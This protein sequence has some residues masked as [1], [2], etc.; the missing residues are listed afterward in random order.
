MPFLL[1]QTALAWHAPTLLLPRLRLDRKPKFELT[2]SSLVANSK[3]RGNS[4]DS[5]EGSPGCEELPQRDG[6]SGV[7]DEG[8][9]KGADHPPHLTKVHG[10]TRRG[11]GEE[12]RVAA[13][14]SPNPL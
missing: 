10:G 9:E 8:A 3:G 11:R 13:S 6:L 1:Q 2:R 4:E 5:L 14:C 12:Q 7:S